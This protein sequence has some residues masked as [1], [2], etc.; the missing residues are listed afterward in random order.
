MKLLTHFFVH[1]LWLS[2]WLCNPCWGV[3][4]TAEQLTAEHRSTAA[5][6]QF[7]VPAELWTG[8]LWLQN[9]FEVDDNV[10]NSLKLLLADKPLKTCCIATADAPNL[11]LL[12]ELFAASQQHTQLDVSEWL[13]GAAGVPGN[14][15]VTYQAIWLQVNDATAQLIA[16]LTAPE[17]KGLIDSL[18]A[19]LSQGGVVCVAGNLDWIGSN[20]D[21][22]VSLLPNCVMA[23]E[24]EASLGKWVQLDIP[25][26]GQI[27][28]SRR[29]VVCMSAAPVEV[30]LAATEHY[31]EALAYRLKTGTALDW[32]QLQRTL[33]ERWEPEFP[34]AEPYAHQLSGGALVIGGGGGM[35]TE[36]WQRFVELAGGENSRIVILPTAVPEPTATPGLEH[37]LL[38]KAGAG[39][40]VTLPQ[41][42]RLEVSS[43]EYLRE[44]DRATGIW[45]GGGR[46]WHFVDAYW[47]TPAWEKLRAVCQRGGVIGG[48]SAGATIQ[49]DVLVRGAPA[50]NHV[51]LADGYRHGLGLLPGIA[52]DQHF[53]QRNR[54]ADLE[55]CLTPFPT[56]Y[57][58]GIDEQTALVVS[59]P[60]GCEVIG[61]GSVWCYP[62]RPAAEPN[63]PKVSREDA[64]TEHKSGSSFLLDGY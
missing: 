36:V 40:I 32:T 11:P 57:G 38:T 42:S 34:A 63:L 23:S 10:R 28:I 39:T 1:H 58:I 21:D 16:H 47:G 17:K 50:G 22:R 25:R 31:P 43:P 64:R 52:I 53:A 2:L 48:S 29:Q 54:F 7:Y 37:R 62:S 59:A 19:L 26:D 45:L 20:A 56:V 33:R 4:N 13:R 5:A 61:N 15:L 46:Q 24:D 49:G 8:L 27:A 18:Q 41:V 9:S 14:S 51:M 44:L 6:P 55:N 60:N 12:N 30:R 35:P 3:Q